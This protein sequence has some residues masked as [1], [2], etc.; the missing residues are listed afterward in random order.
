MKKSLL[1]LQMLI[2]MNTTTP[3]SRLWWEMHYLHFSLCLQEVWPYLWYTH[4]MRGTFVWHLEP[5]PVS[6]PWKSPAGIHEDGWWPQACQLTEEESHGMGFEVGLKSQE[7]A[8]M[9][10]TVGCLLSYSTVCTEEIGA[11]PHLQQNFK[12]PRATLWLRPT[13]TPIPTHQERVQE[14]LCYSYSATTVY[15]SMLQEI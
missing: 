10:F 14:G 15:T 5:N 3:T 4:E 7:L 8:I 9:Q 11:R 2:T 12:L 13:R 6:Q 1:A